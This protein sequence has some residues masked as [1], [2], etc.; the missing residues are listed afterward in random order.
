MCAAAPTF[1]VTMLHCVDH[2]DY[3]FLVSFNPHTSTRGGV[4][5]DDTQRDT[6][7]PPQLHHQTY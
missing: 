3:R 4:T 2:T 7:Q 5:R 6:T 1:N